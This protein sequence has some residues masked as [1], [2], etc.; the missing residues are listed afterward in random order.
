M[1]P[2]HLH[3]LDTPDVHVDTER[4]LSQIRERIERERIRNRY[5]TA[6][7]NGPSRKIGPGAPVGPTNP[8]PWGCPWNPYTVGSVMGTGNASVSFGL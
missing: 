5:S 6:C 2:P 8:F 3:P 7:L 1:I 4:A